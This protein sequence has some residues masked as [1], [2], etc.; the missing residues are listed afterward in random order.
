MC[1]Q[2]HTLRKLVVKF[3]LVDGVVVIGVRCVVP[4]HPVRS[5][6]MCRRTPHFAAGYAGLRHASAQPQPMVS[7]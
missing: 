7:S 4:C 6:D 1:A 3:L 2:G 5:S